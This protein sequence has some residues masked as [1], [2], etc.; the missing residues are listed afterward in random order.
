[1]SFNEYCLRELPIL[2]RRGYMAVRGVLLPNGKT[3]RVANIMGCPSR[4]EVTTVFV[5]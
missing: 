3:M 4:L 5:K 1:M 2:P